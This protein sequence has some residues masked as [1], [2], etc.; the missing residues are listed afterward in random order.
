MGSCMS[1]RVSTA[2]KSRQVA[3][4]QM[5]SN[6]TKGIQRASKN[7]QC[8]YQGCAKVAAQ[9][10]MDLQVYL[11][12]YIELTNWLQEQGYQV[13]MW[14]SDERK[15]TLHVSWYISDGGRWYIPDVD[16][17]TQSMTAPD[18]TALK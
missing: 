15:V 5:K 12:P 10:D 18:G 8:H 2:E 4:R 11:Q 14:L 7:G 9:S 17:W 13:K 6:I 1:K 3:L 16:R